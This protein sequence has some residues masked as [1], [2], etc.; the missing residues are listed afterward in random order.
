MDHRRCEAALAEFPQLR[1]LLQLCATG[2]SFTP[3][4]NRDGEL[5]ELRGVRLW[6]GGYADGLLALPT[7][8]QPGAHNLVTTTLERL[9][10]P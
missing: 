10:T 4:R 3:V 9:W 5:A 6:P 7:P 1:G 8:D 2:W